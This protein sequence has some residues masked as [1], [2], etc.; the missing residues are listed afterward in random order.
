MLHSTTIFSNTFCCQLHY[1][2][3]GLIHVN[4]TIRSAATEIKHRMLSTHQFLDQGRHS[5]QFLVVSKNLQVL[6]DNKKVARDLRADGHGEHMFSMIA[7]KSQVTPILHIQLSTLNLSLL[8]RFY[9][10]FMIM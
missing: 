8:I 4:A 1:Y 6:G 2:Y 3:S 7:A 9:I 5:N 10:P